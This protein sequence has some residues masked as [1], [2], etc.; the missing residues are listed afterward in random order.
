MA[1]ILEDNGT[2]TITYTRNSDA[3]DAEE[4]TLIFWLFKVLRQFGMEAEI[5]TD[6][7]TY[8]EEVLE[9]KF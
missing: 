2:I 9:R 5:E 3:P 1:T 4:E 6:N 7:S 8:D